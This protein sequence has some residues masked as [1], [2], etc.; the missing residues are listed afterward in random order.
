[1]PSALDLIQGAFELIQVYSPGETALDPDYAR[2]F[3]RLNQMINSWSNESLTTYAILEQNA[4]LVVGQN[5]YTIGPGGDFN[6]TRPIR[7]VYGPGA[8]YIMDTNNNRYPV[9]VIPRDQWNQIWNLVSVTSNLPSTMF[10]DPQFPLGVIG[11]FPQPNTSSITL[12][13]DSYLQ[14]A[15]FP[16]L[17][18]QLQL[19]P[20]YEKAIEEN[21]ALIIAP[22]FP[23]AVV[24]PGLIEAAAISKGNV[25]RSNIRENV[26]V[27]DQ[28]IANYVTRPYNIYSDSFR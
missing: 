16:S 15:R 19:P 2:G 14:I 13:W 18:A 17:A 10:Y 6:M 25:K 7:V 20:G 4:P 12:F 24:S 22:V 5:F 26:A 27:Y 23:T 11:I 3:S 21:L 8:A 1:M 28:E 9:N